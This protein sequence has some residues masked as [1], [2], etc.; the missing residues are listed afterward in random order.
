ME[1]GSELPMRW[2]SRSC[3]T[4]SSLACNE[5][6]HLA[7]FVQEDGAAV[8]LFE[9][10]DARVDGA[11]EGALGVAEELGF[12]QMIGQRGAVDGHHAG[13]RPAARNMQRARG[14]FLAGAGF[15]GDENRGTAVGDQ[16][17]DFHYLAHRAAGANQQIARVCLWRRSAG[18]RFPQDVVMANG[19]REQFAKLFGL[20]G[21]GHVLKRSALGELQRP[22]YHAG[23]FVEDDGH[24]ASFVVNLPQHLGSGQIRDGQM[25]QDGANGMRLE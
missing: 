8:R 16:I 19:D 7:D 9:Q 6:R 5:Q 1:S 13:R 2:I 11:R 25:D 12:E 17:D 21:V 20:H 15:A 18:L 3:K 22:A 4:R 14:H 10:A 24:A 23:R